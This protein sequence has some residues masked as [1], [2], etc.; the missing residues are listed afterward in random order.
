MDL[1]AL[2][3]SLVLVLCWGNDDGLGGFDDGAGR[4]GDFVEGR[5]T[6]CEVLGVAHQS[7]LSLLSVDL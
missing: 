7:L 1:D 6:T 5:E 2:R 4:R 3:S